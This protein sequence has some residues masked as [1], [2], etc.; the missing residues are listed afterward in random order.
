VK[1]TYQV[2]VDFGQELQVEDWKVQSLI[3][4]QIENARVVRKGTQER[5]PLRVTS[6]EMVSETVPEPFNFTGFLNELF[7]TP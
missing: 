3:A 4:T 2:E 5:I 7:K 1:R 6:I